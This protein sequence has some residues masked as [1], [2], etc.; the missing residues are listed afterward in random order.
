MK[1]AKDITCLVVDYGTFICL[2]EKL[3]ESYKKV[4][5]HSPCEQEY[6]D[7][8]DFCIGDGIP[9]VERLNEIFDDTD[10]FNL[11]D[12][13]V[14][15]DI[16]YGGLQRYLRSLGKKVWGSMGADKL[17]LSRTGFI[18]TL[19]KLDLPVVE[20][21][22]IRGLTNLSEHLKE[23]DF[24]WIKI[25]DWRE[26][27]ETWY[28]I[29]YLHSQRKL[30]DMA[31]TFGGLK[32]GVTFVVQDKIESDAEI[33][34]DGWSVGGKFPSKSY[35]GYELKNELYLGSLLSYEDLP[36]PVRFVG[37]AFSPVL[38]E[39]GYQNFF[40]TEIRMAD[41]TPYFIDPTMRMPGQTG[42]QMLETCTNLADVIW[43]GANGELIEP[44]YCALFAAEATMHYKGDGDGW[45]VLNVPDKAK[46]W[47]KLCQYCIGDD[48]AYHFPPHAN[49]EVG[50]IMG[51]GD[52]IEGA[53]EALKANFEHMKEE[54]VS[55]HVEGFSELL[56]SIQSAEKQGLEFTDQEIPEPA[57]V[58]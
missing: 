35:Q 28:H 41:D 46:Q 52:T 8:G 29:D 36:E 2:A 45:K 3:S 21:V 54:P 13:F 24:K 14:F 16:G 43:A 18:K 32:E 25:N 15:P 12:L 7:L 38:K 37:E 39:F 10:V 5:Y 23:N 22:T 34:Y 53:I 9:N 4:Y 19:K 20:S 30:E 31:V 42:E 33:G 57:S 55:I 58:L 50:I 6:R 48:D 51:L 47:V 27:M 26:N 11:I 17:E 1:E 49:D 56:Q 44:E 40:A